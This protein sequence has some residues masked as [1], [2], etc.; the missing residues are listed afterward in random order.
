MHANLP[1]VAIVG[2]SN[3]GKSTLFNRLIKK[4]RAI[5]AS[6]PGVTRDINLFYARDLDCVVADTAGYTVHKDEFGPATRLYNDR[7]M[8]QADLLLVVCDILGIDAEDHDIA[9]RARRSGKPCILVLNK[10]DNE[11]RSELVY[12]FFSLGLGEPVPVS[13]LHGRHV[14]AL[15]NRIREVVSSVDGGETTDSPSEQGIGVAIVG[16]PNVGKSSLLN[17]LVERDRVL[18]TPSPGTTR[19]AV[20]ESFRYDDRLVTC[21]DTAGLRRQSRVRESVEYYS[22][23]RTREA[24]GRSHIGLLLIDAREGVTN[25]DK[26]IA[27]IVVEEKKGLI[28]GANKWDL[29]DSGKKAEREFIDRVRFAFPHVR[30]AEVIP[31]SARTGYNKTR[32]LH[33]IVK[34]YNNFTRTVK[35]S[36]LND[37][38]S[39]L[40]LHRA[41]VMYG[42]QTGT[43][44]P[45]F[46]IFIRGV[47]DKGNDNFRQYVV[48]GLRSVF[49]FEGVP[50]EVHFRTRSRA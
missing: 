33:S 30:F 14:D 48:N 17:L 23:L 11:A 6:E 13:A 32:L 16:K 10:V 31:V 19:D 35:T 29:H 9:D 49:Q 4:R 37:F 39:G 36:E 15:R 26:K 28:I 21:V 12:D 8:E 45:R 20:D 24:I 43:S 18:V 44:P 40:K 46:D 47:A 42:V 5:V 27:S 41:R 2:K 7:L 3:V 38:V 1:T 22:L 25:Q 50:V 34:V